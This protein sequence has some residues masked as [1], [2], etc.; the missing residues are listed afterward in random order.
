LP[1]D[2]VHRAL[3][4]VFAA[5]EFQWR[6]RPD[7][8]RWITAELK[9]ILDA[10]A[11]LY[12]SH[13]GAYFVV[14]AALVAIVVALLVHVGHTVAAALR[15]AAAAPVPVPGTPA[16]RDAAWHEAAARR[17]GVEGRY[18]EALGH[19]YLALVLRLAG[20]RAVTFHPSKTP[21]EYAAEAKLGPDD[22]SA[23]AALTA[24]LYAHLFGGEPCDADAWA[25]FDRGATDLASHGT[26]A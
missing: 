6:E 18:A 24:A 13:P 21:A 8:L 10:L 14:L 22:R 25:R 17:L 15:R 11:A 2:S 23:L 12:H 19:R 16:P 1:S 26:P 4:H 20:R 7:P 5:P 9:S 3:R